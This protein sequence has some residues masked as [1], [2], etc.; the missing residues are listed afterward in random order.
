MSDVSNLSYLA[1]DP[2][3]QA[4]AGPSTV[5][6]LFNVRFLIDPFGWLVGRYPTLT[7]FPGDVRLPGGLLV[8]AEPYR[9]RVHE[10]PDVLPRAFLVP[11][12]RVVRET[13]VR[14]VASALEIVAEGFDP[15]TEV[16][17]VEGS[18]GGHGVPDLPPGPSLDAAVSVEE[19]GP[20]TVRLAVRAPR[21]CWLFLGDTW[22]PGWEARVDGEVTPIHRANIAGRAVFVPRGAR[23]V[24]FTYTSRSLGTG[25]V[26]ALLGLVLLGGLLVG[27]WRRA[28]GGA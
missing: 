4:G 27:R 6:S 26:A 16:V 18:G 1:L 10:N 15:R 25:S 13:G 22:Y 14:S 17:L 2:R 23:E 19:Y 8:E 21:D 5:L 28:R 11:R 7:E 3:A 12:A 9:I 20:R 24:V